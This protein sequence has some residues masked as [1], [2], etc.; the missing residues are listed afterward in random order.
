M[1]GRR[2][3]MAMYCSLFPGHSIYVGRWKIYSSVHVQIIGKKRYLILDPSNPV[4]AGTKNPRL[5]DLNPASKPT[6]KHI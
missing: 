6:T 4:S 1:E 3:Y 2:R 5:S